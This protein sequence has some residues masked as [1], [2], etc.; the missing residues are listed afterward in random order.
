MIE[1]ETQ[2]SLET[3]TKYFWFAQFKGK[4][5]RFV[6]ATFHFVSALMIFLLFQSFFWRHSSSAITVFAVGS[7]ICVLIYVMSY[8][9]PKQYVKKCPLL[10]QTKNI[11][12]FNDDA[13]LL[14]QEGNIACGTGT[15]KYEALY[16]AYETNHA[17][18]LYIS[19]VQA[20][21]L[22]KKDFVK[23]TPDQLRILLQTKLSPKNYVLCK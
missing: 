18:Y 12:V 21:L 3:Y 20:Y 1:I 13:I 2:Y 22:S 17:I 16:K 6:K 8:I 9:R 14:S 5:Y 10:F 11:F 7:A 15:V 19:P 4:Y 23:G